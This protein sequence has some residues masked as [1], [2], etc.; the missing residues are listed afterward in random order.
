LSGTLPSPTVAKINGTSFAGTNGNLVKTGMDDD[1]R[2]CSAF[3]YRF[4]GDVGLTSLW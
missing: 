1:Q 2:S 4:Q 3:C